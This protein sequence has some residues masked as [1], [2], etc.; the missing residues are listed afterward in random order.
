MAV[1]R[2]K[3]F[4]LLASRIGSFLGGLEVLFGTFVSHSVSQR[5]PGGISHHEVNKTNW[6]VHLADL[7]FLLLLFHAQTRSKLYRHA[8][9][10]ACVGVGT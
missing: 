3:D 7:I 5:A 8:F 10:N 9:L 6:V 4:A 2:Y 1:V